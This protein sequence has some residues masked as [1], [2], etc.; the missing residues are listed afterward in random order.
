MDPSAWAQHPT[1]EGS[2]EERHQTCVGKRPFISKTRSEIEMSEGRH[3]RGSTSTVSINQK[4]LVSQVPG[5]LSR[6]HHHAGN[7]PRP[8][9]HTQRP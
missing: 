9:I 2:V 7:Q 5:N 4:G 8:G 6:W 3:G 1:E